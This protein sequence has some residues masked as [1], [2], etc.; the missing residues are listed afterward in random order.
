M[1][2]LFSRPFDEIDEG[3]LRELIEIKKIR[4][5]VSLDYKQSYSP[6]HEGT[7]KLLSDIAAMA[8]SNGGYIIIGIEEDKSAPDGTPKC[9]IGIENGDIEANRI[10]SVCLSSIDEI[11]TGLRVRDIQL[12]NGKHCVIIQ[13]PNSIKKPHMVVHEK[14]RSFSIRHGRTNAFMDMTQV[15]DMVISM[16]SYQEKLQV[17]IQERIRKNFE[18]AKDD[19]FLLL[20]V[21]PVYLGTDKL[22]PLQQEYRKVISSA[23]ILPY[24]GNSGQSLGSQAAPRIFGIEV[25]S[26]HRL[27]SGNLKQYLR[28]FRNGHLEYYDN[29]RP[30][31]EAESIKKPMQIFSYRIAFS[32]VNFL[33]TAQQIYRMSETSDPLAIHLLLGNVDSSYLYFPTRRVDY[34]YALIW[35]DNLLSIDMTINEIDESYNIASELS[36]RLFNAYGYEKNFH[37]SENKEII[38]E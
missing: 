15:R 8:N 23:N 31:P 9:I 20:M 37:F 2:I 14:H 25:N 27:A 32:L 34:E 33:K 3:D 22:N 29:Y 11:I 10:Q 6:N 38:Y 5:Y 4:E 18:I 19:P 30:G 21:T 24:V 17:F 13:I 7:V 28:L 36:D 16:T 1:N 35:R 26:Y 12:S